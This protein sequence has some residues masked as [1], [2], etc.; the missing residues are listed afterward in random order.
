MA[1][2]YG[3]A[4]WSARSGKP[5]DKAKVESAVLIAE[6]WI[7][8]VLRH[9]KFFSLFRAQCRD[10]GDT[11]EVHNRRFKKLP[12][13]RA[14]WFREL[15]APALRALPASPYEVARGAQY[16]CALRGL[17]LTPPP[18]PVK[19]RGPRLRVLFVR[20]GCESLV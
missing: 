11:R 19:N 6:R 5:R 14:E 3:T 15:D 7:I 13:T 20:Q 16:S 17:V 12:G 2:H 10:Q 18:W 8:A 9:R 4:I 1:A